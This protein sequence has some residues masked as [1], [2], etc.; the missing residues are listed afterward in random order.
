MIKFFQKGDNTMTIFGI[1]LAFFANSVILLAIIIALTGFK[2]FAC[3]PFKED[4]EDFDL[5]ELI[6]KTPE[7]K[8]F[9]NNKRNSIHFFTLRL[10]SP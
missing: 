9:T 7:N 4:G 1:D 5:K 6:V 10:G 3:K 2:V 8:G